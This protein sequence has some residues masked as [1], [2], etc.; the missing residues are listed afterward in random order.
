MA[1]DGLGKRAMKATT[2]GAVDGIWYWVGRGVRRGLRR[3]GVDWG[4]LNTWQKWGVVEGELC[5][6][7]CAMKSAGKNLRS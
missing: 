3:E 7:K 2:I 5:G 6:T 1:S 4:E